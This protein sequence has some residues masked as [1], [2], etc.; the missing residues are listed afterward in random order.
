M[1]YFSLVMPAGLGSG[2]LPA[3]LWNIVPVG[4]GNMIGGGLLVALPFWFALRPAE[5]AA[6]V[7]E[8]TTSSG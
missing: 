5:R 1:G 8:H 6:A 4:N 7:E 2:W 3:L